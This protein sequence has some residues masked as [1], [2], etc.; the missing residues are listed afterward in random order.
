[1]SAFDRY[2]E[3]VVVNAPHIA[4][5]LSLKLEKEPVSVQR[6]HFGGDIEAGFFYLYSRDDMHTDTVFESVVSTHGDCITSTYK[7]HAA[8]ESLGELMRVRKLLIQELAAKFGLH[9]DSIGIDDKARGRALVPRE[10]GTGQLIDLLAEQQ[11]RIVGVTDNFSP[12]M[13]RLKTDGPL[14]D[15]AGRAVAKRLH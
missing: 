13:D 10:L 2:K 12:D 7:N 5:E 9:P 15:H 1:M 4:L 3:I 8:F 6:A 14:I 11:S